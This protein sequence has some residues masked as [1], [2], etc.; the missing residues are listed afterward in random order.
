MEGRVG[1]MNSNGAQETF[2][3]NGNALCIDL[4]DGY[5]SGHTCQK[6]LSCT[7]KI[8]VFYVNFI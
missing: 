1:V 2:W 7:L 4:S 8:T 3:N 5:K 6:S